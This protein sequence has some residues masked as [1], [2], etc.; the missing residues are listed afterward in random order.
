MSGH[1]R[2]GGFTLI[3]AVICTFV[4]SVMLLAA[5]STL[6]AARAGQVA[7]N[8][9]I[10]GHGLA[11]S[12]MAEILQRGYGDETPGLEGS[13]SHSSRGG[14]DDVDDYHNFT[15]TTLRDEN[16][17]ALAGFSGWTRTVRVEWVHPN[18]PDTTSTTATGVKRITV[19]ARRNGRVAARLVAL[20]SSAWQDPVAAEGP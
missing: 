17:A 20:R 14:L 10:V 7:A 13:E 8:D 2:H 3:E 5:I 16:G 18:A 11:Q 1:A 19:E 6:A 12:L 9:T 4:V 15:E